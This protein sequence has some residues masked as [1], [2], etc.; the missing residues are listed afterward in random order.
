VIS[1]HALVPTLAAVSSLALGALALKSRPRQPLQWTF[2]LGMTGLAVEA[3]A[4]LMLLT[5]APGGVAF[6]F[7]LHVVKLAGVALLVPWAFFVVAL[8]DLNR[9]AAPRS[10]RLGLGTG[11]ALV[12]L[13]TVAVGV[14][15]AFQVTPGTW[16]TPGATLLPVAR[17]ASIVELLLTVGI[18]AGL[19]ACLRTSRG[20]N[21]Q[22]V[23]YLVLG[24][25]GIFLVRFY[26]LSQ[27]L[28]FNTVVPVFVKTMG[29]SLVVANLLIAVP[30]ARDELRG[31][32]LTVSRQMV[33]RSAVVGVL[34]V[35]LFVVAA[36]GSLL[37]YLAVPE[38]TFWGSVIV[39]ASALG[40]T[41]LLLSDDLRWRIKRF[42]AVHFYRSKYDY[43][44]QWMA[45]TKRM[46]SLV[47]AE[48][49]GPE[50]VQAVTEAVGTTTGALYLAESGEAA[51]YRLA[52]SVGGGRY[53]AALPADAALPRELRTATA[54]CEVTK[55][56]GVE[57]A[58]AVGLTWRATLVGFIVLGPERTGN[59]YTAEDAEFLATVAEQAAGSLMNARL[60]EALAHAREL[61]TFDR[62]T[63]AV[64]HDVKNSVAALS[65]LSRNALRNFDDPEFQRDTITTLSRTVERM[66]RLLGKLSSPMETSPLRAE[67][68]DLAGVVLE[69]T[70]PLAA[71]DRVRLRRDL[72]PVGDVCGD[73]DALLRVVENLVTNAV[74]AIEGQGTVTVKLYEEGARAV[75]VVSDT[76]CG[77]PEDF[78]R[79][80]LFSPFRSTKKGG[81]GI[82]LYHTKQVVERHDGEI[83][84]ESMEGRGTTFW[85]RLP[86]RGEGDESASGDRPDAE[87]W[88]RVR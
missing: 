68:V 79:R 24:L 1:L 32:R 77:I 48:E 47:T 7:W 76:G 45:F 65:L 62:V 13:A 51:G 35:Y 86:L 60:S 70:T 23:K 83:H 85:V 15:P 59:A 36:L 81:W 5:A 8:A 46:G 84:V 30:I 25:G 57:G 78:L 42:I 20:A 28:L 10:W 71:D 44:E 17:Y 6:L 82:G 63:S 29:A 66:T 37:T 69:A 56:L 88:E 75:I 58:V 73:R 67:R 14:G 41:A 43:R 22:R 39:F 33:Y 9:P 27:V 34:G 87:A 74:E 2:A 3:L 64:I 4:A 72:A 54:P 55:D 19:E 31:V 53:P 18:L 40:L 12:A 80:F 21:R 61:E 50:L 26:L 38:E 49:L 16:R 52:G 11:V